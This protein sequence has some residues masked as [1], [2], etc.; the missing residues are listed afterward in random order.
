[1]GWVQVGAFNTT[2]FEQILLQLVLWN[3]QTSLKEQGYNGFPQ[4]NIIQFFLNQPQTP[5]NNMDGWNKFCESDTVWLTY[6]SLQV[7]P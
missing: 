1:M 7:L 6:G 2:L 3:K 5:C 4:I